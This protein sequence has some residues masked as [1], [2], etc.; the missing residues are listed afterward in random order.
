MFQV[1]HLPWDYG[2]EFHQER[3]KI[4]VVFQQ[5]PMADIMPSVQVVHDEP[6]IMPSE[7]GEGSQGPNPTF[8]PHLNT[9]AA[10]FNFEKEVECL[11]FKLNLG[12]VSCGKRRP[13]Q[14]Y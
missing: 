3:Q 5:R 11:P 2:V 10:D 14:I 1:E 4:E 6:D 9:Q 12:D 13:N 7:K 8:G